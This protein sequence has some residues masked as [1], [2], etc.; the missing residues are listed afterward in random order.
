M[1][2]LCAEKMRLA[3][4]YFAYADQ[5]ARSVK[6]LQQQIGLATSGV[7]NRLLS[8][9]DKALE[10][11]QKNHRALVEHIKEHGC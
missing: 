7:R 6:T 11:C 5:H 1:S 10:A 2:T 3:K 9:S 4:S 8:V